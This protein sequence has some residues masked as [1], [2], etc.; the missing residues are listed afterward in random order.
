M[1]EAPAA[2]KRG[3]RRDRRAANG[4]QSGAH[5]THRLRYHLVFVPKYRRRVLEGAIASR[6]VELFESC[7]E[8]NGWSLLERSVQVDHVHLLVQLPPDVSVCGAVKRLKGGSSRVLRLEFC[9]LEE[10]LWGSSFWG[11][12]YFSESV[13]SLEEGVVRRYIR[14]QR[15]R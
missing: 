2:K 7:C 14:D 13:G 6:L 9:D 4:Y 15:S 3:K 12:G 11:V 1:D 5:T 10:F 8:V